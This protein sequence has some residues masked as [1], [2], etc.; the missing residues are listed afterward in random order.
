MSHLYSLR[1]LHLQAALHFTRILH[2]HMF[3]HMFCHMGAS[4]AAVLYELY[5]R[6]V[7]LACLLARRLAHSGA[8]NSGGAKVQQRL[9]LQV[10]IQAESGRLSDPAGRSEIGGVDRN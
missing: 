6:E 3:C 8:G 1:K 9:A 4:V 7:P 5:Q 10:G 2:F